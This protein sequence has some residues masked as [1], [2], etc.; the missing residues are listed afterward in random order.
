M[1]FIQSLLLDPATTMR[2]YPDKQIDAASHDFDSEPLQERLHSLYSVLCGDNCDLNTNTIFKLKSYKDELE[3]LKFANK[4]TKSTKASEVKRI[5]EAWLQLKL[6]E[7]NA[8]LE[9]VLARI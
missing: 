8:I 9:N 7:R 4:P 5:N 3:F 1:T 6:K 2:S